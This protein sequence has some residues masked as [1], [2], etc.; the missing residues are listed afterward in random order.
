[1]STN[2]EQSR[3]SECPSCGTVLHPDARFCHSCGV[4]AKSP[5][6][7]RK[8]NWKATAL[9]ATGITIWCFAVVY[10]GVKFIAGENA[11][12]S[13]PHANIASP[14]GPRSQPVDLSKITP[15]EAADRLFN[16]VMAAH[17][18]GDIDEAMRFAPMALQAYQLVDPLDADARYHVGLLSLVTGDIENARAQ[19]ENLTRESPN[20]LLGLI[21]QF[22]IA[23]QIGDEKAASEARMQFARAYNVQINSGRPEYE[24]HRVTIESFHASTAEPKATDTTSQRAIPE[25]R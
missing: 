16:R 11:A 23:E 24:A 17:E 4:P 2:T 15:L 5:P 6:V 20:H 18:N 25:N 12:K 1:M 3:E 13:D 21:L 10:V 7:A 22:N 8:G 9:F 14:T 19:I